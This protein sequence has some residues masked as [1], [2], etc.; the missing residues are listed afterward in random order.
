MSGQSNNHFPWNHVLGFALSIFL[1]VLAVWIALYTS[2]SVTAVIWIIVGLA[3]LQ[4]LVQLFMFMHVRE[5]EGRIQ[6]TTMYYSAGIGI[7]IVFGTIWV[8]QSIMS[9][10]MPM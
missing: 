8:I 2:L 3:V 1:T 5:G 4:A 10:S 6:T 9:G 7:I